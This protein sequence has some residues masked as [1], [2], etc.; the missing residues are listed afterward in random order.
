[1]LSRLA[2][3]RTV[4]DDACVIEPVTN[5][6][7]NVQALTIN[8]A[9]GDIYLAR[10]LRGHRRDCTCLPTL[11]LVW[12]G[13]QGRCARTAARSP[14]GAAR[15]IRGLFGLIR[16]NSGTAPRSPR[17]GRQGEKVTRGTGRAAVRATCEQATM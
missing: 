14:A 1:V 5:L 6:G 11:T 2:L 4:T 13:L 17:R 9:N 16:L 3:C 8:R 15:T 7:V 12:T 10:T